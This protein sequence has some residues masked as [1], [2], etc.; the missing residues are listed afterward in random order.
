MLLYN[1]HNTK[2]IDYNKMSNTGN[3]DFNASNC[4]S[5]TISLL[6]TKQKQPN[7][8][9]C[10]HRCSTT[11]PEKILHQFYFPCCWQN[12][13]SLRSPALLP[14]SWFMPRLIVSNLSRDDSK[15]SCYNHCLVWE[16]QTG[17]TCAGKRQCHVAYR[18]TF[19]H[20]EY[21]QSQMVIHVDYIDTVHWY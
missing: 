13:M 21:A 7:S 2:K 12:F 3:N 17:W 9:K 4:I 19:C 1:Y 16:S 6:V 10:L 5:I 14:K 18:S 20:R 11:C 15:N 8:H